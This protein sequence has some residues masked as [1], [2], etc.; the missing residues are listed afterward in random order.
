MNSFLRLV[1]VSLLSIL[2]TAIV[3]DR[4]NQRSIDQLTASSVA[5]LTTFQRA[6]TNEIG[7]TISQKKVIEAQH[8]VLENNYELIEAQKAIIKALIKRHN[9]YKLL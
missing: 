3:M 1:A 8:E 7:I 5:K 6:L 4:I 2:V 9:S